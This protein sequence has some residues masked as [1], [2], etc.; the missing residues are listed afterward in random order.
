[1]WSIHSCGP[2]QIPDETPLRTAQPGI[3]TLKSRAGVAGLGPRLERD[4][5]YNQTGELL[6]YG[7]SLF[8]P[9]IVRRVHSFDQLS[10]EY[11]ASA[12]HPAGLEA[13]LNSEV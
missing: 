7:R 2:P 13:I 10:D 1:M 11:G 5:C 6:L 8:D 4:I 9:R 12:F 3:V